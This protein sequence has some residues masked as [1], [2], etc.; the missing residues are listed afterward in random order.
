MRS[1]NIWKP[2]KNARMTI[3][4][5]TKQ[6]IN[7]FICFPPQNIYT[8]FFTPNSISFS[9]SIL[10]F[11]FFKKQQQ[12]HI[13]VICCCYMYL[14]CLDCDVNVTNKW[15]KFEIKKTQNKAV[16]T[17]TSSCNWDAC[18][19]CCLTLQLQYYK[20]CVCCYRAL[21]HPWKVNLECSHIL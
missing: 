2:L 19:N 18:I 5:L 14:Y 16:F 3:K 17:Y 21:Q 6:Y 10:F 11:L 9:K 1:S 20:Q 8:I 15:I 13:H 12:T 4:R 7:F